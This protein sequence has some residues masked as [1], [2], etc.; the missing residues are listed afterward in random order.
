MSTTG[1]GGLLNRAARLLRDHGFSVRTERPAGWE[2]DWVVAEDELFVVAVVSADLVRDLW[3]LESRAVDAL[4]VRLSEAEVGAKAWD[5]YLV[6]ISAEASDDDDA[7]ELQRIRQNTRGVR[8]L[9]AVGTEN[10][11]PGVQEALRPFLPLPMAA[12][13]TVSDAFA[14]LEKQLVANGI[15]DEIAR[16]SVAAYKTQGNLN[17][18]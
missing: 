17:D 4:L 15:S 2:S 14:E 18:V 6:L 16:S 1:N 8:R 12:A 11:D 13:E 9:M 7:A 3:Q 5:A 10:T